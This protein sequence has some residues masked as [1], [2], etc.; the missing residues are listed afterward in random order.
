PALT[1]DSVVDRIVAIVGPRAILRSNVQ[2]R[3]FQQFQGQPIPS[4]PAERAR[5]NSEILEALVSEELL[6]QEAGRDTAIKVLEEDVTKAADALI[7]ST[8]ARYSGEDAYRAD[9]RTAGF[10]TPDEYRSWVTDLQRRQLQIN[11][12]MKKLEGSGKLK[13]V[14]PTEKELRAYFDEHRA[15]FGKR[16][17]SISF[18]QIVVAPPPKPAAKTRARALADS[19]L[20]ELRK[21]ADFVTASRRFSMDPQTRET[22]GDIGWVRRG[23]GLDQRFE[24]VAF[25]LKPGVVS[26]PIETPFG[27]HL[28]QVTRSQPAEVQVRHILIRP[29]VDQQDADSAGRT[30]ERVRESLLQGVSFDSL[31]RVWHDGSEERDLDGIP[32]EV[33]PP[34]Y[35]QVVVGLQVGAVSPVFP[36]QEAADPA[37]SKFAVLVVTERIPAGDVRYEDVKERIRQG[38][39]GQL[40]NERYLSRLRQATLVEIR[41]P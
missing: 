23:A 36:L 33:L 8:R 5:L 29:E 40:T 3:I 13:P 17:E 25:A 30:A 37:R 1:A 12:L 32:L 16:S 14:N 35:G 6:V 38:L 19:I 41:S 10:E 11:E 31:Q 34:A 22:G 2:E 24:D 21:G 4:D 9:L 20:V 7:R 15:S 26:D 18:R 28:I 39:S 27:Y